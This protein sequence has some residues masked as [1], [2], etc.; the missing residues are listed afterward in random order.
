MK[1]YLL[2][3][4]LVICP[5]LA[6]AQ[7]TFPIVNI[8]STAA[9]VCLSQLNYA[10]AETLIRKEMATAKR[11]KK[12][13]E[14]MELLLKQCNKGKAMLRNTDRVVVVD[15]T[16]LPKQ[17]FLSAYMFSSEVGSIT[18]DNNGL[19]TCYTSEL[20]NRTIR[21]RPTNDSIL[22]LQM[23]YGDSGT[24]GTVNG[25]FVKGLDVAGDTNYPFM[26]MDGVTLYFAAADKEGLGHYDLYVTR[27]DAESGSFYAAE[28]LGFP[29]NSYAND[30]LLVI[31][32]LNGVGWFASDRYQPEGMVCVY[33]FIPNASRHPV[34]FENTDASVMTEWATLRPIRSTWT[35]ENEPQRIS[36]RQRLA[37]HSA[38]AD[39]GGKGDFE[40]V[41]NDLYTYSRFSDF[42]NTQARELCKEWVQKRKNLNALSTQLDEL[43]SSFANSNRTKQNGMRQQILDLEKRVEQ[44]AHEVAQAEKDI[45]RKE[46]Q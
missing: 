18:M 43:R 13:T 19:S 11:Q 4:Y 29:Y 16:V 1:Y 32:E 8:D 44:L 31:D 36:V 46:L 10:R 12:P 22:A 45:R 42:R 14:R 21:V 6:C 20:G 30:Y 33:T 24:Q 2:L 25:S 35:A 5:A 7:G 40:L 39:Q 17:D 34:D 27:F 26:M 15:S 28:N 41:I 9:G 38:D 37:L 3:A 23:L